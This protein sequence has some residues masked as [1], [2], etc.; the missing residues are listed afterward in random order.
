MEE[1]GVS[2]VVCVQ[3][4]SKKLTSGSYNNAVIIQSIRYSHQSSPSSMSWTFLHLEQNMK[5]RTVQA[6]SN[7]TTVSANTPAALNLKRETPSQR[8][9]IR[10]PGVTNVSSFYCEKINIQFY[11]SLISLLRSIS[12]LNWRSRNHFWYGYQKILETKGVQ[13]AAKFKTLQEII[14]VIIIII[15]II[16]TF[17]QGVYNYIQCLKQTMFPGYIL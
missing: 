1:I 15:I 10:V 16:A 12:D 8:V 4:C 13:T 11:I 2:W 5:T 17:M 7:W 14:V 9:R 3:H 6:I